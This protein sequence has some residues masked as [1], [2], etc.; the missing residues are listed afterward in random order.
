[1]NP[2]FC[3][4]VDDISVLLGYYA[5]NSSKSIPTIGDKISFPSSALAD[6]K[7]K[8]SRNVGNELSLIAS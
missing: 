3:R 2:S 1:M 6:G 4:K 5:M 8:L 7:Y